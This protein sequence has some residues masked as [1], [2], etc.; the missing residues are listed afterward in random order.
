MDPVRRRILKTGAGAAAIAAAPNVLAQQ[1]GPGS[2]ARIYEKGPVRIRFDETGSGFPLLLI[3]GGGLNSVMAGL[4]RSPFDPIAEFKNEYRCIYADL[5]NANAGQSTGP[6]E[7]DR[8]WDSYADD[9]LGLMDHLRVDKF[10]VLGFCIGGPF[11]WNLLKR[12]PNR[13]V[14]A[15]T[16]QPVGFRPEM[17]NVMYDASMTGWGAELVK[18]RPEITMEMLDRFVTRMFR[19]NADFVFTVT[20][21]FVRAC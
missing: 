4:P 16:A 21:D 13:V 1:S 15:V 3:A 9:H 7:I 2:G 14:A 8:P 11:I 6:L 18:R 5:R 10:M 12:A 20:R 19:T 17:P